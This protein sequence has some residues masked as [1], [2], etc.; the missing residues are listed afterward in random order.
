MRKTERFRL[1]GPNPL[2]QMYRTIRFLRVFKN[3]TVVLIGRYFPSVKAKRWLY[4][5]FLGMEIGE[6]SALALMVT[7]D[8]MF[9]ERISI[10]RNTVIGFNSTILCH[11]YLVD[12][13][14]IGDVH[15]GDEVLIG[16]NVTI[17]PGVTIGD[18]AV[19]GAGA[20]V[21]RDVLPGE[22]VVGAKLHT[23]DTK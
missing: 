17:L 6:Y 8:V 7:P 5:T 18:R 3:T 11:E 13:Y 9:P 15:I 1:D 19:I 14:R 2:W 20:V 4:Q 22:R 16:A 10:G 21:H 12:E 23:V